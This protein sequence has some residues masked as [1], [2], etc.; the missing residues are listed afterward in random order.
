MLSV[1]LGSCLLGNMLAGKGVKTKKWE[2]G[3][4]WPVDGVIQASKG[5]ITAGQD[6]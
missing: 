2:Q 6:I 1:T 5:T 4:I 3:D